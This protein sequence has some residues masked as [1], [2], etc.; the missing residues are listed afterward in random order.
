MAAELRAPPLLLPKE[1]WPGV[2]LLLLP[3][4]LKGGAAA[5]AEAA[6]AVL[7]HAKW[8]LLPESAAPSLLSFATEIS[9]VCCARGQLPAIPAALPS[10]CL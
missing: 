9:V 3:L 8:P 1:A 10:A 7:P 5:D 4:L 2:L 6:A